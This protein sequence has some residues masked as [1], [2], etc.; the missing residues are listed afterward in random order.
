MKKTL[1]LVL[2]LPLFFGVMPV[3]AQAA[4]IDDITGATFAFSLSRYLKNSVQ[5]SSVV[6]LREDG[7]NTTA[8]FKLNGSNVLISNDVNQY[9]VSQWLTAHSATN[10]YVVYVYDQSGNGNTFGTTTTAY[11]P[12][13]VANSGLNGLPAIDFSSAEYRLVSDGTVAINPA[14]GIEIHALASPTGTIGTG[15]RALFSNSATSLA[16]TALN[17]TSGW[18]WQADFGEQ[19]ASNVTAVSGNDY[20]MSYRYPTADTF[21]IEQ[22]CTEILNQVNA[23]GP[24]D[25]RSGAQVMGNSGY[26]STDIP[27][28]GLIAELVFYN[29]TY[30][31]GDLDDVQYSLATQGG[32]SGCTTAP[33]SLPYRIYNLSK[34]LLNSGTFI[35]R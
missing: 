21:V 10:A 19:L 3:P 12:L 29:G 33:V 15:I 11:Q 24:I 26:T 30:S 8:D 27:W 28:S 5:G 7:G 16:Y 31:S 23:G 1:V 17:S 25:W 6:Q 20:Q 18:F 14:N 32:I 9:T 22:N 34:M 2:V 13:F 4:L 35:L